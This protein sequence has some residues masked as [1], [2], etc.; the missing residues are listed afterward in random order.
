MVTEDRS[1]AADLPVAVWVYRREEPRGPRPCILF[2]HGGGF[3]L[4][5]LDSSDSIA[6][7]LPTRPVPWLSASTIV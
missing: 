6:W 5:D 3:M 7:V 4:G 2:T 1:V